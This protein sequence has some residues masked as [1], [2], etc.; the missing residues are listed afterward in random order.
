MAEYVRMPKAHYEAACNSIRAKTGKGD[1]IKSGD[2]SA[3]IDGITGGSGDIV[4]LAQQDIDG[5]SMNAD[6]GAF[7]K[8]YPTA[9]F[10]LEVGKKYRVV[11]DD[12]E[13]TCTAFSN[14][15]MGYPMV[16]IGNGT[17][18]LGQSEN[19]P[20]LI[21]YTPHANYLSL[22][23]ID[24]KTSHKVAVYQ[25]VENRNDDVR[26][27]TFMSYDGLTEEGRIPVAV[28][29][30]CPNPKFTPTR[31]STAQYNYTLDGWANTP[32]GGADANWYK[33]ITEDKTVYAHF[34]SEVRSYTITYL[35]SDGSTLKAEPLA[36]GATPS[37]A[38]TKTDYLFVSW[39]PAVS[40]VTGDATYTATWKPKPAFS[41]LSWA[42][43][44]EICE[45][46]TAA[47]NFNIGDK[48]TVSVPYFTKNTGAVAG[49]RDVE[50][51]IIGFNAETKEDGT[52]AAITIAS[53]YALAWQYFGSTTSSCPD[54]NDKGWQNCVVRN[55]LNTNTFGNLPSDLRS[56]IKP[57]QK[58]S[59]A[60]NS[61]AAT[62]NVTTVDKLWIPS[63]TEYYMS[64]T[65]TA[66][67][68]G[69]QYLSLYNLLKTP[70]FSTSGTQVGDTANNSTNIRHSTRSDSSK[71]SSYI[72]SIN[73]RGAVSYDEGAGNYARM[74]F[75]I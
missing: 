26:Y 4:L 10:S 15:A 41:T 54:V 40:T 44:A 25:V 55:Y 67:N 17:Q 32:N 20:F 65:Y 2:M 53:T 1:L 27:V 9:L 14:S 5:F 52:K 12:E 46:G 68:Q 7:T 29:Y 23:A 3:E 36:Y 74:C 21:V 28:G 38:P 63:I 51:Q 30:D 71:G 42:E 45:A 47:S 39:V 50:F 75:C 37:Y 70:G 56:I 22:F 34:K 72:I 66:P 61:N 43:I 64:S 69:S 6:F 49:Y 8:D 73:Y 19:E 57:V 33:S 58:I 24:N 48:K 11:W 62:S 18:I 16:C 35:D 59:N 60:A 13:R 31:E